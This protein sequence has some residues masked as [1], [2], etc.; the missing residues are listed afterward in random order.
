M[1]LNPDNDVYQGDL[2]TL[3]ANKHA[4]AGADK[5]S[6]K[7]RYASWVVLAVGFVIIVYVMLNVREGE[8][9]MSQLPLHLSIWI[10]ALSAIL[11]SRMGKKRSEKPFAGFHMAHF[12]ADDDTVY[13]Q[14]QQ[15][16]TLRTYYIRDKDIK[17]IIRDD[18]AGVLLISGDATVNIQ[19]RRDETEEKV[20]EF[21]AL[22][23][24]DKY[25]L[26]DLLQPY[27]RKVKKADGTLRA[28]F[29]EEHLQ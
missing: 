2:A 17:K 12:E 3:N 26:D 18:E 4:W 11:I 28:K 1:T 14:Y 27:K 24:F 6:A 9:V 19:T 8:T 29:T 16:M 15:G 22:V 20:S 5:T 23:P 21:Y 25:D 13:Y 7:F 10:T